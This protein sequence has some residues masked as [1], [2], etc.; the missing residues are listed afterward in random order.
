MDGVEP[1]TS[2]PAVECSTTELHSHRNSQ[3][4]LFPNGR[5]LNIFE[6]KKGEVK[7]YKCLKEILQN[8]Y[9]GQEWNCVMYFRGLVD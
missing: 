5:F 3:R 9:L 2:Q 1:T 6:N 7:F 8:L 4:R